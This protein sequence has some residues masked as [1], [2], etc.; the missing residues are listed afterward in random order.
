M[1]VRAAIAAL[2]AFC[3]LCC[4]QARADAPR[5][6][7]VVLI[8]GE[9]D[10]THPKGT[11]EYEKSVRLLKH[12]L[13]TSPNLRGVRAEVHLHGWP[14]DDS[15]LNDADAIVIVSS[16]S[17]RKLQ[18][19]PVLVGDRLQV[20]GKQMKRGCGLVLIHWT[21]F[22]P[23]AGAGEKAL[24]RV[25]GHFD[26]QSGPPPRRWASAIQN[27]TTTARPASPDHPVC[28]GLKP[29]K[30]REEFYYRIRFREK[31]PRLKPILRAAIPGEAKEQTVAWAVERRDGG[32]GFGF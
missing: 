3:V 19:H 12:C 25:G 1:K 27:L 20:L 22:F 32:R 15:T 9:L 21:T 31:D 13:E 26:D 11:H 2:V 6:R 30:V 14:R 16:G 29:F 5:P 17:D 7:K 18:D 4:P 23:N 24:E 10:K 8:A 28:R